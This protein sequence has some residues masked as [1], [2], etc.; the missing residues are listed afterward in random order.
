MTHT[1]LTPEDQ[2]LVN[3]LSEAAERQRVLDGWL[4]IT[5]IRKARYQEQMACVAPKIEDGED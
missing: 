2:T 4:E 3:A 1:A 5:A